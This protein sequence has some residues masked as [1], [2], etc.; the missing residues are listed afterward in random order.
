MSNDEYEKALL[1]KLPEYRE[2][3]LSLRER[4]LADVVMVGEIP[5]PTFEEEKVVQFICNRFTEEGLDQISIDEVTNATGLLPGT[6]GKH[7]ILVAAHTDRIWQNG[8]DHT[9]T[10]T[11]ESLIGPGIADNALGVTA[12]TT[13]PTLLKVLGVELKS[14]LI[15]LGASRSMGRGDLEG[16]R[17][18]TENA[19][20]PFG[21]AVCVEGIQL[22]RLSYSSLGMNRCEIQ[23]ITPEKHD[24]ES[25]S[26]TGAITALTQIVQRILAIETPQVPKTSIILGSINSGTSFNLPPTQATLRFEVRSEEPGMVTRI[27]E[28]I[29]EILEQNIAENGIHATMEILARRRPGSIGFSHPYVRSAREILKALDI[30]PQVAPSTSELSVLLDKDI[31]SLTLGLTEGDNKHKLDEAIRIK[32]MFSGLAQLIATLQCIDNQFEDE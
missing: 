6:E 20:L 18:F 3:L 31:P 17:F 22:G 24:W 11:S 12:L 25:W 14:N 5:S 1:A 10:V 16:L 27:R 26:L 2:K 23:V 19:K 29:E 21:A 15:L 9:V 28:Q 4:I 8:I 7:N 32:P 30:K 13:L